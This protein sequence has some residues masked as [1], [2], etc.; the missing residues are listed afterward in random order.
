MDF[1]NGWAFLASLEDGGIFINSLLEI[2]RRT[3]I[4]CWE[5]FTKWKN[6]GVQF[7]LEKKKR[8]KEK[9]NMHEP[10]IYGVYVGI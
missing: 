7:E 8:K 4:L 1:F 3:H 10:R 9:E 2:V 5:F 6:K